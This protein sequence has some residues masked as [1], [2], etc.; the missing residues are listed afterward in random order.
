MAILI[1]MIIVAIVYSINN[2][3]IH[4]LEIL[5]NLYRTLVEQ[6]V[7]L[8]SRGIKESPISLY[9]L[10]FCWLITTSC[11]TRSFKSILLNTYYMTKPSLTV[12]TLEDI[13]NRPD[14]SISGSFSLH[15]I[16][17]FKPEFFDE[18]LQRAISYETK[19][20]INFKTPNGTLASYS[21][22]VVEKV[23]KRKAVIITNTYGTDL[24]KQM[25]PM[26]KLM[27]SDIKYAQ[28]FIYTVIHNNI[29]H[30]RR[31]NKL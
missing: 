15:S 6:S 9:I 7:P 5:A 26:Y 29:P 11:I 31:I 16:K 10:L 8:F 4:I 22:S 30:Y 17:Q 25:Y 23:V 14:L 24:F 12:N 18:L 21:K 20:D 2:N 1:S 13:V 27:E 3:V 28:L 19:M